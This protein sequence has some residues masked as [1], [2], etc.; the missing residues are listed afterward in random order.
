[1]PR[2]FYASDFLTAD[3]Y[4]TAR[5]IHC[6]FARQPNL[7]ILRAHDSNNKTWYHHTQRQR[8]CYYHCYYYCL[9]R[10][11]RN[12]ATTGGLF[13]D[14]SEPREL[15][16][17]RVK[18]AVLRLD[19]DRLMSTSGE[20]RA[21]VSRIPSPAHARRVT[22]RGSGTSQI[23][24]TRCGGS[25]RKKLWQRPDETCLYMVLFCGGCKRPWIY[26]RKRRNHHR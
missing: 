21:K 2:T 7:I 8:C 19:Y 20:R 22:A 24:G 5:H 13:I 16:V 11:H 26:S 15:V 10:S 17:C 1:M 23:Y 9:R 4:N 12:G 25:Y 3:F 18:T 6:R 14:D